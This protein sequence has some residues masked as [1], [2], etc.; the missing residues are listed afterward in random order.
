[1][2]TF[3][4]G[5]PDPWPHR[6][7]FVGEMGCGSSLVGFVLFLTAVVAVWHFFFN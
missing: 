3:G 7:D 5:S 2:N 1:M 4:S 6:F